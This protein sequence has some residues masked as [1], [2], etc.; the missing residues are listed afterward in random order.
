MAP[1]VRSLADATETTAHVGVRVTPRTRA[2]A[3]R[4][5]ARSLRA[6]ARHTHGTRPQVITV[7]ASSHSGGHPRQPHPV[8]RCCD[9]RGM[10]GIRSKREGACRDAPLPVTDGQGRKHVGQS[11][12]RDEVSDRPGSARLQLQ[13]PE[14]CASPACCRRKVSGAVPEP[15]ARRA[16]AHRLRASSRGQAS[17]EQGADAPWRRRC[18]TMR[19]CQ[20]Q[21]SST[22]LVAA[23]SPLATR[24]R[25]GGRHENVPPPAR[26]G[27]A[28]ARGPRRQGIGQRRTEQG[29]SR[30]EARV[31]GSGSL[32]S[33]VSLP[34]TGDREDADP[35][36]E[37]S[38]GTRHEQVSADGRHVRENLI[39]ASASAGPGQGP[40]RRNPMRPPG[41]DR[42]RRRDRRPVYIL[43]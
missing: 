41:G 31:A 8:A 1:R 7:L 11:L 19:S 27:S 24:Y 28:D 16:R 3:A 6:S 4:A 32:A 23:P 17:Q 5:S 14:P 9:S 15:N 37:R 30:R 34:A 26:R 20:V 29:R 35:H 36:V 25:Y 39:E 2:T 10:A 12:R 38:T 13:A 22:R 18:A 43:Q 21:S 42:S 40:A 33:R